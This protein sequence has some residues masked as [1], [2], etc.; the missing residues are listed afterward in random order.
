MDSGWF[1][2]KMRGLELQGGS[3]RAYKK[4]RY[5]LRQEPSKTEPRQPGYHLSATGTTL[6]ILLLLGCSTCDS[7]H[8]STGLCTLL[9]G[10]SEIL[11]S[12]R[13]QTGSCSGHIGLKGEKNLKP[14]LLLYGGVDLP[15]FFGFPHRW[16][17]TLVIPK[18]KYS[19][20][21]VPE[22]GPCMVW[23]Q[24]WLWLPGLLFIAF[25]ES[26]CDFV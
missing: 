18:V 3:H 1:K 2:Q 4:A 16:L 23:G 14:F 8:H 25:P 5:R 11:H 22:E 20:E 24:K 26:L 7:C 15:L 21:A 19:L 6:L 13:N 17:W 10:P 9:Q 12:L